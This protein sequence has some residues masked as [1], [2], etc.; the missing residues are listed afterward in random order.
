[1]CLRHVQ[2]YKF[3]DLYM[4]KINMPR[5]RIIAKAQLFKKF[6]VW[7]VVRLRNYHRLLARQR[8]IKLE[9]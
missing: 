7:Y 3:I 1:M 6:Q 9:T 5:A 4:D 2:Q 8:D